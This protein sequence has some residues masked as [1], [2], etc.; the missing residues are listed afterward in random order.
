MKYSKASG[1][2]RASLFFT[3]RPLW[4][5]KEINLSDAFVVA[6][7]LWPDAV[8]ADDAA[9]VADE[10]AAVAELAAAVA[11]LAAAVAEVVA[12]AASTN[13]DHFALSVLVVKG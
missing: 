10:A 8:D 5:T 6:V 4:I 3:G 12:E 11:E 1:F 9:P 13:N 7:S 2:A